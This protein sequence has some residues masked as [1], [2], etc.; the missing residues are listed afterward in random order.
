M[1]G[2][3]GGGGGGVQRSALLYDCTWWVIL[4]WV[5]RI[6]VVVRSG[7]CRCLGDHVLPR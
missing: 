2:P 3:A 7:G 1:L 5:G 6:V 4:T